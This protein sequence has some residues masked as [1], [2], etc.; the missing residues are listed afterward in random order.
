MPDPATFAPFEVH[1]YEAVEDPR[2]IIHDDIP[3]ESY[4][5]VLP[6]NYGVSF[7]RTPGKPEEDYPASVGYENG[8][9]EASLMRPLPAND[10]RRMF[11]QEYE[12]AEDLDDLTTHEVD[13]WKVV[14]DLDNAGIQALLDTVAERPTYEVPEG[15]GQ[16]EFSELLAAIFGLGADDEEGEL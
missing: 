3:F 2:D 9:W 15:E 8:H 14:G 1:S 12:V 10:V 11:G 16:A 7:A 13:G 5:V 4:R 6:N